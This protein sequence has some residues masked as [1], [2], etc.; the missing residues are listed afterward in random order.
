M[1]ILFG[2]KKNLYKANLH[3]HSTYSDGKCSV[4]KL[5]ERYKEKGYSIIAFTDHEHLIDNSRLN[6][7]NFLAITSCEV[8]IKQYRDLS[9]LKRHDMKVTHLNFYSKDPHNIKTP[10]YSSF[11]DH[12]V[13]DEIKDIVWQ[14]EEYE[15]VYSPDGINAMIK[16]AKEQGFL[17]S[18]NHPTWSL[19]SALDYIN[20]EGF[21]FVEI[22]N[23][24]CALRGQHDD[25]TAFETLLQNGKRVFCTAAD[26]NHNARSFNSVYCDSFG[27]WCVVNA[28]SLDYSE[29]MTSLEN[30]DFYASTG[31][32]LYSITENDGKVQVK[33]SPVKKIALYTATRR[34]SFALAEEGE[35][36]DFAELKLDETDVFFRIRVEDEYGH[37]AWSQAYYI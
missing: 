2:S 32:E 8:A 6:D 24:S 16:T 13:K 18:Y 33:C 23:N 27:G 20:Y 17:V 31:C 1:K 14:G 19:E 3:L 29:I 35:T 12:Y 37:K 10:C 7:D 28:D 5:K 25:E 9:T 15:R 36:I 21:D 4:E 11:Y 22:Y 26:D 30:G 34:T